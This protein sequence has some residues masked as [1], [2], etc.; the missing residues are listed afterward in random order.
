MSQ[1]AL[2]VLCLIVHFFLVP[3]YSWASLTV[4]RYSV[5]YSFVSWLFWLGCQYQC[6]W[7]TGKTRLRNDLYCIGGDVKL[8]STTQSLKL[9]PNKG[10]IWE[11]I[12]SA[13]G[14]FTYSV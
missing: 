8:N 13:T 14:N 10:Q 1:K 3:V 7:L 6:K 5:L 9:H 2:T 11:N 12:T 4:L